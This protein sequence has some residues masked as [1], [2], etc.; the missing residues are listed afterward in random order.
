M[1]LFFDRLTNSIANVNKLRYDDSIWITQLKEKGQ[2]GD[3]FIE[4][5]VDWKQIL[6]D[7]QIHLDLLASEV[8]EDLTHIRLRIRN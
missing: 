2:L 5:H 7:I 4:D 1:Q 6:E 8:R 3:Y